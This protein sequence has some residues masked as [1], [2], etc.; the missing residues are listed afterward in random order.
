MADNQEL[1]I[2]KKLNYNLK[3]KDTKT[4]VL[5]EQI[6]KCKHTSN[7]NQKILKTLLEQV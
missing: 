1:D 4:E 3:R 5:Y 2:P 6:K 7:Q